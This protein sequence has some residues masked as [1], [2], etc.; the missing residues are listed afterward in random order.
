MKKA[1]MA[2]A[3]VS[4]FGGGATVS[5]VAWADPAADVTAALGSLSG[6]ALASAVAAA[7]SSAKSPAE[8]KAVVDAVSAKAS[9]Q[10][11]ATL[12]KAIGAAVAGLPVDQKDAAIK[13]VAASGKADLQSSFV[14]AFVSASKDGVAAVAEIVAA[15]SPL[16]TGQQ[17]EMGV[18]IGVAAA[19]LPA[20]ERDGV[21]KGVAASGNVNIQSSFV[22]SFVTT[23]ADAKTAVAEIV[24]A[25]SPL[26]TGQQKEMGIAIG[27]AAVLLPESVGQ[28]ITA[29]VIGSSD[30]SAD[31]K[32]AYVAGYINASA[33]P[34]QGV[35]GLN[36]AVKNSEELSSSLGVAIAGAVAASY[37]SPATTTVVVAA[38]ANSGNPNL[39][40]SYIANAPVNPGG[41]NQSSGSSVPPQKDDVNAGSSS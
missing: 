5:S 10:Q 14:E 9:A 32:S 3:L 36:A 26:P 11:L 41:N 18:A 20:A 23:S 19:A 25:V 31:L 30:A 1:L 13:A 15:V 34:E 21:I 4:A 38:I 37:L 17:K 35:S 7:L 40:S 29:S 27:E 39:Q 28:I 33:T 22:A 16:P 24:K 8:L 6:D 2:F 12:G